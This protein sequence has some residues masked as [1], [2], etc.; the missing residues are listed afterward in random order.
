MIDAE[1]ER[2]NVVASC[3]H[4]ETQVWRGFGRIE[5]VAGR[6]GTN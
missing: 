1:S 2:V 3:E 5:G 6:S 4:A